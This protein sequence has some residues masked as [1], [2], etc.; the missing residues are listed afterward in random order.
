MPVSKGDPLCVVFTRCPFTPWAIFE[1][2]WLLFFLPLMSPVPSPVLVMAELVAEVIEGQ[3]AAA[4]LTGLPCWGTMMAYLCKGVGGC[5]LPG[6]NKK[7]SQL[8]KGQHCSTWTH[9]FFQE[10]E[11]VE[12][13]ACIPS[14]NPWNGSPFQ[15]P[16]PIERS[17]RPLSCDS[18]KINTC[19]QWRESQWT[20]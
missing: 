16:L 14:K 8:K 15:P 13:E 10:G 19:T 18:N 12:G 11:A 7:G 1:V 5:R 9:M 17:A 20:Y 6:C 2:L 3:A 4:A